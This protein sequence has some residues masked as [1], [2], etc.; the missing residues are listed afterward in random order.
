MSAER[1]S[2]GEFFRDGR[3]SRRPLIPAGAKAWFAMPPKRSRD[4]FARPL[5]PAGPA[6]AVAIQPAERPGGAS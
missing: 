4:A 6:S 5:I 3:I 1:G 2:L